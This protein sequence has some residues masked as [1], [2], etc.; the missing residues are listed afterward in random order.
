MVTQPDKTEAASFP[1]SAWSLW[2]TGRRTLGVGLV[3]VCF[4]LLTPRNSNRQWNLLAPQQVAGQMQ[5]GFNNNIDL[6]NTGPVK[7]SEEPALHVTVETG[8]G[9]PKTDLDPQQLWRGATLDRYELDK[10]GHG[11]WGG[12]SFDVSV[13][14]QG[15]GWWFERR[16]PEAPKQRADLPFLGPDQYYVTFHVDLRQSGGLF[17]AEPVSLPQ[18]GEPFRLAESTGYAI[19]LNRRDRTLYLPRHSYRPL[20]LVYEQVVLPAHEAGARQVVDP[21]TWSR[22]SPDEY[23]RRLVQ[24]P[25]VGIR[26]WTHELLQRLIAQHQLDDNDA[27][28]NKE[29][30]ARIL[31]NYLASSGEFSYR[32][33]MLRKNYT[34]DPAEDFLRNVR[35]GFCE[36]YASGLTLMLRSVGIP[37]RVVVGYRGADPSGG[38]DSSSYLIR[39]SHAHSW[40]EA[41]LTR[42]GPDGI[43]DEFYW[44]TLDPTP[45]IEAGTTADSSWTH[46]WQ[47]SWDSLRDIGRGLILDYNLDRQMEGAI[48][49]WNKLSVEEGIRSLGRWIETLPSAGTSSATAWLWLLGGPLVLTGFWWWRRRS[50]GLAA[51]AGS[52]TPQ[53]EFYE[54]WLALVSHHCKLQPSPS[55]TPREFAETVRQAFQAHPSGAILDSLAQKVIRLYY[56]VRF[57]ARPLQPA[58]GSELDRELQEL[59]AALISNRS[60]AT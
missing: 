10:F 45:G 60:A 37:A 14:P 22:V 20:K 57:G 56:Q 17:L 29:K 31:S 49:L 16:L 48:A 36:H 39:Q 27:I 24:Q 34:M 40:V 35:Q 21:S 3:A 59:D 53:V 42:Q 50:R 43:T 11:R 46:W 28:S 2:L 6:N 44:L 47:W 18:T 30:V 13:R 32:L 54:R 8:D 33:E 7:K 5:T 51:H 4:F 41:L 12:R 52:R 9:R 26:S 55:Q 38:M 15:R 1:G 19:A 25:V 23:S 58:E